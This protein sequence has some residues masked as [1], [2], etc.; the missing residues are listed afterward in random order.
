MPV[1]LAYCAV[2]P[3]DLPVLFGILDNGFAGTE[4][5]RMRWVMKNNRFSY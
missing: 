4:H 3:A 1:I 2:L 5:A